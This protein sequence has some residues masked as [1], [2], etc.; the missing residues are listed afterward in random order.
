MIFYLLATVVCLVLGQYLLQ[1]YRFRRYGVKYVTPV[2]L[3]GNTAKTL[4]R[5]TAHSEQLVEMYNKF[6]SERFYGRFEF[7]APIVEV[8]D[9]ELVKKIVVKD[10]DNFPD[11]RKRNDDL[12]IGLARSVAMM[13]GQDWK[14]MRSTLSPA[15]TSS[16]IR[17]MVPFMVEV[18]DQMLL[19]LKEKMKGSKTGKLEI[20][21]RDLTA[22][23]ANDVIATCAFGLKVD[24]HTNA[25]NEFFTNGKALASFS[26]RDNV[27]LLLSFN[28]PS[29]SKLIQFDFS[30]AD[31]FFSNIFSRTI[32]D[33]EAQSTIRPDLIHLLVEANK[34]K[35][36]HEDTKSDESVGFATV[37]E[38]SIGRKQI[39]KV[40]AERDLVAQAVVFFIAGF[41]T[42]STTM[43]FLMYEMAR[44]PDVQE[45]L[46]QEIK[47]TDAK[48][49]GKLDFEAIQKMEYL[50]MVITEV[51]RMW[52][53]VANLDRYCAKDYNIGKPN[54]T[55]DKDFIVKSGT[56]VSVPVY[57]FHRDP[58]YYPN[59][60]QFDPERFSDENKHKIP[61]FAYMPFGLG[62]RNCIGSRFA[63]CELKIMT[64]QILQHF[65]ISP[66]AKT[67]I[68]PVI[69]KDNIN[70]RIKGGDWTAFECRE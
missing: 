45:R 25:V 54:K 12:D 60:E 14:D 49:G 35:L 2:P 28:F 40:W 43:T 41:E 4:L 1:T 29:L 66:C 67:L 7:I 18:G 11:R 39:N 19:S 58:A 13:T 34:G 10:F 24:S 27:L 70:L 8:R 48:N 5:I 17:L 33:R 21:V 16:K 30:K 57:A 44:N 53:P 42:I 50:D 38:S 68:P 23:Y 47:E 64:Y 62:P 51:L 52:P 3:L 37:E 9:V 6:S 32:K 55:A 36:K 69:S 56:G 65:V 46:A 22:R 31:R 26:F 15:F 59:P 63:L 20:N 61:S